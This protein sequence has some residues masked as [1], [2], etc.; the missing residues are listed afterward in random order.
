MV[1]W[2]H[3]RFYFDA[4]V[5]GRTDCQFLSLGFAQWDL[6]TP[7]AQRALS[8]KTMRHN[9][10]K[11]IRGSEEMPLHRAI[12]LVSML[13]IA[14]ESDPDGDVELAGGGQVLSA[15]RDIA[16]HVKVR[17]RENEHVTERLRQLRELLNAADL[18]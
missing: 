3:P 15:G 17:L 13:V 4:D 12:D 1:A 7:L 6:N 2:Y 16:R 14:R 9:G 11:W 8:V 5:A 18:G 10:D